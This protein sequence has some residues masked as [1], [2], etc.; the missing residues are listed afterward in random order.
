MTEFRTKLANYV[1]TCVC[2]IDNHI[3]V[4]DESERVLL[5][6]VDRT[7]WHLPFKTSGK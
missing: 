7:L 4:R 5:N 2:I 6:K 1:L 3:A